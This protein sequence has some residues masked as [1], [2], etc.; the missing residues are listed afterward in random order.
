MDRIGLDLHKRE[1]QLCFLTE[2]GEVIEQ[3]TVSVKLSAWMGPGAGA[4]DPVIEVRILEGQPQARS[5]I[6]GSGL[7]VPSRCLII[8]LQCGML[9]RSPL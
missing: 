8:V 2:T 5:T 7:V 6:C 1:S 3:D 4:L 9:R